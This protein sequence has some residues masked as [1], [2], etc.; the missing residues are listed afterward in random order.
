M[1][2]EGVRGGRGAVD[3]AGLSRGGSARTARRRVIPPDPLACPQARQ[4]E[5]PDAVSR[6]SASPKRSRAPVEC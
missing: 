6:A 3:G 1:G 4:V 5:V 2:G